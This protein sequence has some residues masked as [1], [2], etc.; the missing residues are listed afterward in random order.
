MSKLNLSFHFPNTKYT[1][2]KYLITHSLDIKKQEK[3]ESN[4]KQYITIRKKNMKK[5][6]ST[7]EGLKLTMQQIR[8]NLNSISQYFY[9]FRNTNSS[10]A[11]TPPILSSVFLS[12]SSSTPIAIIACFLTTVLP[13][14]MKLTF[15]FC[16]PSMLPTCPIIPG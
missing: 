8:Y 5:C 14:L 2:F 12:G 11:E 10:T 15:T 6:I 3:H 9:S 7:K 4:Q 1:S 13:T 16:S